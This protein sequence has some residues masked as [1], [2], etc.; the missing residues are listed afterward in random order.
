MLQHVHP[1]PDRDGQ[2]PPA[3]PFARHRDDDRRAQA[4][5]LAQVP[6]DGLGLAALLGVEAGVGA[7]RVHQGEDGT[8]ELRGDLHHAHRLA[9]ALGLGHPEVAAD[10]L[11]GVAPLLVADHH[12]G[13]AVEARQAADDG[14]V[15][16]E[17]A[18]AVQFL[19]LGEDLGA[20]VQ[21]L[22]ALRVAGDL[23]DLPGRHIGVD[24][25][26]ELQALLV[27]AV[28]LFGD[29]D[30]P[31]VLHVAQLFDLGLEFGDR[32]LEVEEVSFAHRLRLGSLA[33]VS[34]GAVCKPA[35]RLGG[36]TTGVMAI[37]SPRAAG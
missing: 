25:L 16:G 26:G 33:R 19:E 32:L 27:E 3:A 13:L 9:V 18:I 21:G 6:G 2:G 23:I 37:N 35:G 31:F 28:D 36:R 14:G 17:M 8:A 1:V 5:H 10:L 7:R 30:R 20:I 11:L 12:A 34:R 29:V 15:I 4:R 24:V 22:R